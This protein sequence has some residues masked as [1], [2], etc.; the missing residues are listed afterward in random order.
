MGHYSLWL[1]QNIAESAGM[2]LKVCTDEISFQDI[3][4]TFTNVTGKKGV[5]KY[6]PYD[7]YFP[8]VEPFPGAPANWAAGPDAPRDESSMTYRQNFTAWWKFWG[9]GMACPRDLELLNRVH[10]KR[11]K[12]LEEWM[13]TV[14]YDGKRR[15]VLKGLEDLQ[16][17]AQSPAER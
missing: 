14:R 9:E 16:R 12:S 10:P 2:N 3:A 13:R 1:F 6:L 5:H 7:Q 4:A 15:S 11:I 17:H 8:L